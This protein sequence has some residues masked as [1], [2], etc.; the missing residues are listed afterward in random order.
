MVRML[1]YFPNGKLWEFILLDS[2]LAF[3]S[4]IRF[5]GYSTLL[6]QGYS[7]SQPPPGVIYP[8]KRSVLGLI[9]SSQMFSPAKTTSP[10]RAVPNAFTFVSA[11]PKNS[12][13]SSVSIPFINLLTAFIGSSSLCYNRSN[14]HFFGKFLLGIYGVN[15]DYLSTPSNVVLI[16]L[17]RPYSSGDKLRDCPVFELPPPDSVMRNAYSV[18]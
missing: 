11:F 18:K 6:N 14:T 12:I 15:S 7:Y 2:S 5:S 17:N 16:S 10:I 9:S 13:I 8:C 4:G 1:F 3:R